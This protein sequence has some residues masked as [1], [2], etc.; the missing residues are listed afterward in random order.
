MT[1]NYI[2]DKGVPL[3]ENFLRHTAGC[4][5]CRKFKP[6]S[7]ASAA[8]L[9]ME[10]AVLWKREN[11]TAAVRQPKYADSQFRASAAEVKKLMRY[12]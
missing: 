12:K 1:K 4:D 2:A 3:D 7:P 10:G 11:A 8:H 9:C 5:K 6:E